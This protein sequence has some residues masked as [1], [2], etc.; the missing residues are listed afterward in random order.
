MEPVTCKNCNN[1]FEGDYCN[2]CG[3]KVIS[4][5]YTLNHFFNHLLQGFDIDKG[6]LFTARSLFSNPGRVLKDYYSGCTVAYYNPLKYLLIIASIY[7]LLMIGF[8]IF[9]SNLQNINE[10]MGVEGNQTQLQQQINMYTRKYMS[11][12]SILILPF[13]SL[14][15]RWI[16]HKRKLFYAEHLILN[17]YF[18]SQY[19]L[20]ITLSLFIIIVF[21][22]LA[23]YLFPFGLFVFIGYYTYGY[24]SYFKVSF[25]RSL[26]SAIGTSLGGMML[27]Y[28]ILAISSIIV[29]I[30]M[31]IMGYD[32]GEIIN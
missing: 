13:Y 5:R 18:M 9:D 23:I 31:R 8:N 10:M 25:L 20:I 17:A 7:A 16:F 6:I 26:L 21:P 24:R 3:Q 30:I 2:I 19:L 28:T 32:L 4:K 27:F 29:F 15:S 22:F 1:I 11:F 14:L 12:I